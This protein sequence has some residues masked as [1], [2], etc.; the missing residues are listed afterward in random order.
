VT[1]RLGRHRSRGP[2]GAIVLAAVILGGCSPY[3]GTTAQKVQQWASQ[4]S[5]VAN[6][7]QIVADIT[8]VH[9]AVAA[10]SAKVVRTICGGLAS[11]VG[12]AYVTLPTPDQTLTND[13]NDADTTVV[14]ASTSCS[15]VRSVHSGSMAADLALFNT[16]LADL[17]KAQQRLA[18]LGITWK[19]RL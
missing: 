4:N 1:F 8:L 17:R 15:G 7:D 16:A 12:T 13:L 10:G 11:D 6:H 19:I 2:A 5:F 3:S 18:A 14:N 9:K